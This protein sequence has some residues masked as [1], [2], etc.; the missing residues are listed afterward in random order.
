VSKKKELV[1]PDS[2]FGNYSEYTYWKIDL[3]IIINKTIKGAT[4]LSLKINSLPKN[5]LCE[6]NTYNGTSLDTI[7]Y[8]MCQDW[9]DDD[10]EIQAYEFF[11][12]TLNKKIETFY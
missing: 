10:G 2:F 11:G 6:C 5:G 8:I 9:K 3:E 7:F 12:N 4:S 1:I